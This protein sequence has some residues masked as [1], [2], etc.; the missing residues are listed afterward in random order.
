MRCGNA[1]RVG[2]GSLAGSCLGSASHGCSP[3]GRRQPALGA[4][5]KHR[6]RPHS[7]LGELGAGLG[8]APALCHL[9]PWD[10]KHLRCRPARRQQGPEW[11]RRVLGGLR[12]SGSWL[13][14]KGL[15]DASE[16]PKGNS[17]TPGAAPCAAMRATSSPA[18]RPRSQIMNGQTEHQRRPTKGYARKMPGHH[19]SQKRLRNPLWPRSCA[20]SGA[21]HVGRV[22]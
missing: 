20:K 18:P 12:G 13:R 15:A 3:G 9:A 6:T 11:M 22:W 2:N 8:G 1:A 14:H 10:Q 19:Q 4:R 21:Q 5:L 16:G 17:S 7:P